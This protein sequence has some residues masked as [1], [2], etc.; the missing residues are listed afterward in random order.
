MFVGNSFM[1]VTNSNHLK[2]TAFFLNAPFCGECM[3]QTMFRFVAHLEAHLKVRCL[4][5]RTILPH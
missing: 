2:V 5:L 1:F 3:E 4:I